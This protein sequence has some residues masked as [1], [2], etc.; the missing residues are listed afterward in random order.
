MDSSKNIPKGNYFSYYLNRTSKQ[1]TQKQLCVFGRTMT[2]EKLLLS[3]NY[4]RSELPIRLSR[5]IRDIQNLPFIVG[6]NPHIE[7]I[8][9]LYY[10]AFSR[11]SQVNEIK[12]LQDNHE[13]YLLLKNML[14]AHNRVIDELA[15]GI[16]ET[17]HHLSPNQADNFLSSMIKSRIGQRV[18]A[19]QHMAYRYT[20]FFL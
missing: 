15:V 7:S 3:A 1:I 8:Y 13:F 14:Q 12:S 16:R 19:Q 4:V 11:F 17:S 9:H 2:A 6:A 10:N 18:I 20:A 5:R